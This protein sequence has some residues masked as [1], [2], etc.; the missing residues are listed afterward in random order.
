ME[1]AV[2]KR[3]DMVSLHVERAGKKVAE[4]GRERTNMC[5][6]HGITTSSPAAVQTNR[7]TTTTG[8]ACFPIQKVALR[9][10]EAGCSGEQKTRR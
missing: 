3:A 1:V 4:L 10:A 7:P 9:K 5:S 2:G 6:K 8:P